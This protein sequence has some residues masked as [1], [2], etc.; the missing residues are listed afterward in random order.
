MLILQF[1]GTNLDHIIDQFEPIL[2]V[3][4]MYICSKHASKIA[5]RRIIREQFETE[6]E[7]YGQLY[8][9][10]LYQSYVETNAQINV[11]KN[12]AEAKRLF[13]QTNEFYGFFREH[14]NSEK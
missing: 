10:S 11:H 5:Y 7:L 12:K 2:S 8:L 3:K 6:D 1:D 14:Q 9:D 4:F 13:E